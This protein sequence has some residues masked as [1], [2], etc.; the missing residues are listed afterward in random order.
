MAGMSMGLLEE[1]VHERQ[2]ELARRAATAPRRGRRTRRPRVVRR[3]G[4]FLVSAGIR[5]GGPEVLRGVKALS[6]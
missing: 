5:L 6:V 4:R 3:T 2:A 1:L